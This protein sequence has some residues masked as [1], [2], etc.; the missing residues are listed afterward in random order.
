MSLCKLTAI[1]V[2]AILVTMLSSLKYGR[3]IPMSNRFQSRAM[4]SSVLH[5]RIV[6]H[7]SYDTV[8]TFK[9]A[10]FG[11]EGALYKHKKSGA[12]VQWC[13]TFGRFVMT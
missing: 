13:G 2:F 9:V 10:E 1:I 6:A 5:S 4:S 7:P 8:E 12:Q 11:F 3:R